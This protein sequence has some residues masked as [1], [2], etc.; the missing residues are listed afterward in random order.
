MPKAL[1]SINKVRHGTTQWAVP[2]KVVPLLEEIPD[3]PVFHN[4]YA[5]GVAGD[6][7]PS[8]PY[9]SRN[10]ARDIS[11]IMMQHYSIITLYRIRV[12]PKHANHKTR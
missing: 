6:Y 11:N 4:V 12:I 3:K 5:N 1:E 2:D 7:F 10:I 8:T 9:S